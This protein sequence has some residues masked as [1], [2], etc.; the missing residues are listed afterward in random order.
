ME[1]IWRNGKE[2]DTTQKGEII[3]IVEIWRVD[4]YFTY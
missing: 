1:G 4:Y 3:G 2:R